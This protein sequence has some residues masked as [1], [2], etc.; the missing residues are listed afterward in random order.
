MV[1]LAYAATGSE[2]S[3]SPGHSIAPPMRS[4]PVCGLARRAVATR[5]PARAPETVSCRGTSLPALRSQF[6]HA[7]AR[8]S[9]LFR[10]GQRPH[11]IE[12]A[13]GIGATALAEVVAVIGER[14]NPPTC[15]TSGGRA[16][17]RTPSVQARF[18]QQSPLFMRSPCYLHQSP[19]EEFRVV[20]KL[21]FVYSR[22]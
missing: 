2:L 3:D 22:D 17:S 15:L 1:T 20:Y 9:A 8:G 6:P 10:T 12:R 14:L 19:P 11:D 5:P 16:T 4:A 7:G 21:V 18:L 13:F